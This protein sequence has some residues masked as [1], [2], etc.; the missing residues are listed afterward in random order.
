MVFWKKS[1]LFLHGTKAI[2][3]MIKQINESHLKIK[4]DTER[5][6]SFEFSTEVVPASPFKPNV[7]LIIVAGF[8]LGMMLSLFGISAKEIFVNR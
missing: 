1:P 6:S 8:L 5:Y 7:K 3:V 2:M 4:Y